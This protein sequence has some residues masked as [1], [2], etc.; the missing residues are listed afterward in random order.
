M[1]EVTI[2]GNE[3]PIVQV[4]G[5]WVGNGMINAGVWSVIMAI[6]QVVV[7]HA[8]TILIIQGLVGVGPIGIVD[9][10]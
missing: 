5:I 10:G 8:V 7:L 9:I 4:T 6:E 1:T 3:H 2:I